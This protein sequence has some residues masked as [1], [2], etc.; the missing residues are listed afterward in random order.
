MY[1]KRGCFPLKNISPLKNLF[2]SPSMLSVPRAIIF[3]LK[4]DSRLGYNYLWSLTILISTNDLLYCDRC[5]YFRHFL[6]E[7]TVSL[8]HAAVS[9]R[10]IRPSSHASLASCIHTP[11][12]AVDD[13]APDNFNERQIASKMS[14]NYRGS[15]GIVSVLCAY[16]T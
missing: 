11:A 16:R 15:V 5:R 13:P 2:K 6:R 14:P 1:H 8:G 12:T 9:F 4:F 7:T 3:A 10:G